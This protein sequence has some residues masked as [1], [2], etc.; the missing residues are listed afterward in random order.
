MN[1]VSTLVHLLK[2]SHVDV[3]FGAPGVTRFPLCEALHA[4]EK[5]YS[6]DFGHTDP[7]KT[8]RGFGLSAIT[9]ATPD[10]PV[11]GLDT[12]FSSDGHVFPDIV[13]AS[14]ATKLP[15]VRFREKA[16]PKKEKPILHAYR[17]FLQFLGAMP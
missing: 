14:E 6:V 11:R 16:T 3:T 1:G 9:I 13:S 15:P 7:A 2:Q 8:A 5:F 17:I 4:G 12:A 10:E